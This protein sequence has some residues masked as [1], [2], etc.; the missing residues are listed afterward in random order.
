MEARSVSKKAKKDL[1]LVSLNPF[2]GRV[3]VIQKKC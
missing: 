3:K 1:L 2:L